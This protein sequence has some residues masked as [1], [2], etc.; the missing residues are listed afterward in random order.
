[1]EYNRFKKTSFFEFV[2]FLSHFCHFFAYSQ[3]IQVNFSFIK[4]NLCGLTCFL[5]NSFLVLVL[6]VN[7]QIFVIFVH[8][9]PFLGF[10][11]VSL[12]NCHN[13]EKYSCEKRLSYAIKHF[14]C[15]NIYGF[16]GC[17]TVLLQNLVVFLFLLVF[18][19][20]MSYIG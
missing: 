13:T 14:C 3:L 15:F 2:N 8:S 4:V 9:L 19:F 18:N 12:I 1:M 5:N 11:F 10:F 7:I 6:R 16:K 20:C 17:D